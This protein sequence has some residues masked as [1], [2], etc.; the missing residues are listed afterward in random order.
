MKKIQDGSAFIFIICVLVL[1]VISIMGVWD[2]LG[3]DVITKSMQTVGLLAVV[4]MIVIAAGKFVDSKKQM[5]IDPVTN[6]AIEVPVQI[7]QGFPV[8]RH[9]TVVL[10]IIATTMLAL[11]AV[12][13]I[14]DV[15]SG[16]TLHK[17]L[18]SIAIIVFSSLIIVAVSMER[19]NNKLLKTKIS[20]GLVFIVIVVA[21]IAFTLLSL[22]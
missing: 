5:A 20:G 6:T 7:N 13:G 11:L 16:E 2:V 1:T 3:K 4:S 19:E 12:L 18:S 8:I 22:Y 17:S 9:I 15:L 14:W 21:W 10:L